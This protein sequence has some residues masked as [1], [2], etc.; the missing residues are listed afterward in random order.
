M[1]S[2]ENFQQQISTALANRNFPDSPANLYDPIRYI[3]SLGG[4]RIRP[5]LTLLAA[6]LFG[7]KVLDTAIP[8]ALSIE[9]F[10]NFSLIHDDI[11]DNAPLRRGK[12]TVH[13]KWN[14]SVAI[15][16]GDALLVQAYMELAK[17]P[18]AHVAAL[19]TVFNQV[20]KD[21]CD[22][23]QLDMDYETRTDVTLTDYIEMIRLKTSVLLGGALQ[24]GAILANASLEQQQLIYEFGVDI[25]I[26]FQLQDDMLDVYG[27]PK[28]FG[29]QV[30]GDIISNKKTYLFL[31]LQNLAVAED[32][33]LLQELVK[34]DLSSH[35]QKVQQVMDL[36]GRYAIK[37]RAEVEKQH[38]T[39]AA[40]ASLE[41][42]NIPKEQKQALEAIANQL[43][44]REI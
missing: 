24:L 41:K 28:T 7:M 12:A 44:I 13:E 22:G 21:I 20:A 43:L 39:K 16:S 38:Y 42:I 11:M 18:P 32:A 19:L 9:Y 17:C 4:K 8:A 3:L 27:D 1:S 25:G 36:Y 23:Q 29:K 37:E 30:G 14:P 34:G 26:A 40:F 15:L 2:I 5:L 6:D 31:S 33:V 10:H 35:P